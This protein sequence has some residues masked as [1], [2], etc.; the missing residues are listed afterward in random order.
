MDMIYQIGGCRSVGG[1]GA[2]YGEGYDL[3]QK[4]MWLMFIFEKTSC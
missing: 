4:R 3:E 1:V 2:S